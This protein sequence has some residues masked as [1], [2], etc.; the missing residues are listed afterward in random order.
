MVRRL[1]PA[2][3]HDRGDRRRSS[4]SPPCLGVVR[5]SAPSELPMVFSGPQSNNIEL[6]AYHRDPDEW[7]FLKSFVYLTDVDEGMLQTYSHLCPRLLTKR[8]SH[9]EEILRARARSKLSSESRHACCPWH[10]RPTCGQHR[11]VNGGIP[12]QRAHRLMLPVSVPFYLSL[13]ALDSPFP[14]AHRDI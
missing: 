11:R 7:R 9:F 10:A 13:P 8:E 3:A 4:A 12:P 5:R 2:L 1:L 6:T 14:D